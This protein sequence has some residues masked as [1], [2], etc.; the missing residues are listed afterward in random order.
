MTIDELRSARTDALEI[1][2]EVQLWNNMYSMR[3]DGLR[4]IPSDDYDLEKFI[5]DLDDRIAEEE[6]EKESKHYE[7]YKG[8]VGE[9]VY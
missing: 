3:K 7:T 2:R 5:E 4:S 6:E 9:T 1:L 8:M